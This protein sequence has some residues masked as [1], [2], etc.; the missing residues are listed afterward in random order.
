MSKHVGRKQ[1]WTQWNPKTYVS[2]LGTVAYRQDAW[3]ARLI[4]QVRE[5]P[6]EVGALP[7]WNRHDRWLGP[8]KRPRNAMVELE[9]EATYLRNR[10]KKDVQI[11][12]EIDAG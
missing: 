2:S 6:I 10:H 9:R 3:Y 11:G 7:T 1:R 4:Y 5:K 12:E 8:F